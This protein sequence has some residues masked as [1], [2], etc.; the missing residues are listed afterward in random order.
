MGIAADKK[1]PFFI[2]TNPVMIH[3]GTCQG[4]QASPDDFA[5]DDPYWEGKMGTDISPCTKKRDH[6]KLQYYKGYTNSFVMHEHSPSWN[7]SAVGQAK[8]PWGNCC[9]EKS[10]VRQTYGR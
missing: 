7:V 4:P 8:P 2:F 3:H 5:L 1:K 6:S 10:L 9:S